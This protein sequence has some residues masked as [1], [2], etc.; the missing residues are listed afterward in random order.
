[1]KATL[2]VNEIEH[3]SHGEN[4]LV[5]LQKAGC[6]N[7]KVLDLDYEDEKSMMVECEL[8]EGVTSFKQLEPL[9]EC[10][11]LNGLDRRERIML[12]MSLGT[13][14]KCHDGKPMK[15]REMAHYWNLSHERVRQIVKGARE[16][17]LAT[18]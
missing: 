17:V 13:H 1:M 18:L 7:I 11:C 2:K 5:D 12:R 3:Y 9:P 8:P 4:A 15:L 16:K 6:T 10:V 14:P